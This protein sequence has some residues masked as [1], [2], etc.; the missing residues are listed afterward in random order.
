MA[1]ESTSTTSSEQGTTTST[2]SLDEGQDSI[3]TVVRKSQ[4]GDVSV[5]VNCNKTNDE[6]SVTNNTDDLNATEESLMIQSLQ[7]IATQLATSVDFFREH[8][9]DIGELRIFPYTRLP[10]YWN[11]DCDGKSDDDDESSAR[12]G[13]RKRLVRDVTHFPLLPKKGKLQVPMALFCEAEDHPQRTLAIVNYWRQLNACRQ[14]ELKTSMQRF[15]VRP[16]VTNERLKLNLVVS[17]PPK[18]TASM[19]SSVS[20]PSP[21]CDGQASPR[22]TTE[23]RPRGRPSV[24]TSWGF[25]CLET[26]TQLAEKLGLCPPNGENKNSKNHACDLLRT[27]N[28]E[29]PRTHCKVDDCIYPAMARNHGYCCRH[30]LH[31]GPTPGKV[32]GR[33][34]Y[35][36]LGDV[37]TRPYFATTTSSNT[38][39]PPIEGDNDNG[40]TTT[41]IKKLA[42]C[43]CRNETCVGIG[44][45][46]TMIQF[47]V[48]RLPKDLRDAMWNDHET[49]NMTA[50]THFQTSRNITNDG[51]AID[52]SARLSVLRLAPWH[53]HPEHREFLP[54]GAWK[55]IEHPSRPIPSSF[56]NGNTTS[57]EANNPITMSKEWKGLPLPTYS[58]KDFL[59]E[60]IMKEY[61]ARKSIVAS[62]T[63]ML[64]S[65][66]LEYSKLEEGPSSIAEIQRNFL[67]ERTIELEQELASRIVSFKTNQRALETNL[68]KLQGKYDEKK[69]LKRRD[70]K[71][72]R[73]NNN[74]NNNKTSNGGGKPLSS[75]ALQDKNKSRSPKKK[76]SESM[77][78]TSGSNNPSDYS[79]VID[80]RKN[81]AGAETT[82]NDSERHD[83]SSATIE[84]ATHRGDSHQMGPVH[85]TDH[86]QQQQQQHNHLH[87]PYPHVYPQHLP[88]HHHAHPN[89]AAAMDH[90][91]H[92]P[93]PHY[94]HHPQQ[95]EQQQQQPQPQ[96]PDGSYPQHHQA[97]HPRHDEREDQ[98]REHPQEPPQHQHQHQ[99]QQQQQQEQQQQEQQQRPQRPRHYS[100]QQDWQRGYYD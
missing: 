91:R 43:S 74:N 14:R 46:P 98:Y 54:D 78:K 5:T 65:W 18:T 63:D 42:T 49:L 58:P 73:N 32:N 72:K 76:R 6:S 75:V 17:S 62:T 23:G 89:R 19:P 29:V 94:H 11:Y 84:A 95:Q 64:P 36:L 90:L 1:V 51:N 26:C 52:P 77:D 53:F 87:H 8:A 10:G 59:E 44:Y 41:A 71:R 50:R 27:A 86:P 3:D 28:L 20:M 56:T 100:E 4:D 39:P 38:N 15:Y 99:Q 55:L 40:V 80:G 21:P 69:F 88:Q 47:D 57:E 12:F 31:F 22:A 37:Y 25:R 79:G 34:G 96:P 30:G 66:C 82:T 97:Y 33:R 68:E 81:N 67:W 60:P 45:S 7:K 85:Y 9:P 70:K 24:P 61:S 35:L 2:L 93:P 92:H 83:S 16:N 13:R 48:H